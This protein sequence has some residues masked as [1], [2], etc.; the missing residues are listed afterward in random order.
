[1][2]SIKPPNI[3]LPK[4]YGSE[5][6]FPEYWAVYDSLIHSSNG[7]STIEKIVLLKDSLRGKAER[8]IK[9][10]Q[11]IAKNYEW[12]AQTL[13]DKFGN[14]PVNRSKIIQNFFDLKAAAHN[15][16][17]CDDC[18]DS[19]KA[20][21]NQMVST[22]YDIR[23]NSESMWTET[24]IK[25]FPYT[26]IKDVLAKYQDDKNITIGNLITLLE[27]EISSKLFFETHWGSNREYTKETRSTN[28]PKTQNQR[29]TQ[30]CVF[31]G[32]TITILHCAEQSPISKKGAIPPRKN[33]FVGNVSTVTTQA[34]N[35]ASLVVPAVAKN[36]TK[37]YV[38][39][40]DQ[41]ARMSEPHRQ[42]PGQLEMSLI[43]K[44]VAADHN[45]LI[46]GL[47]T[48]IAMMQGEHNRPT[49]RSLKLSRITTALRSTPVKMN[50]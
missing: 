14:R 28:E 9:G 29:F 48:V 22:D 47:T 23:A 26:V 3:S 12:I 13:K 20:V 33:V 11:P 35:A 31:C 42:I 8:A 10:I 34:I 5:E 19:I 17:S 21:V 27:K 40:A 16:K 25:K 50:S 45:S 30:T 32:R 43:N 6:E 38:W 49:H 41:S 4:F 24:I 7:L 2:R 44:T 37:A 36:I 15:A 39:R 1:M 18:L 46:P